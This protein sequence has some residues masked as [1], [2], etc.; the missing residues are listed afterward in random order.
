VELKFPESIDRALK[1]HTSRPQAW[2]DVVLKMTKIMTT[3][4]ER[5]DFS[6]DQIKA[7]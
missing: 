5:G 7:V 6:D 2:K 1:V 4:R 3:L